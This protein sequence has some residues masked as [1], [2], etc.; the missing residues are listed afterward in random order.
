MNYSQ[1]LCLLRQM[2]LKYI[3]KVFHNCFYGIASISREQITS[4]LWIGKRGIAIS[5]WY[6]SKNLIFLSSSK[7]SLALTVYFECRF[8]ELYILFTLGVSKTQPVFLQWMFSSSSYHFKKMWFW[9]T[10]NYLARILYTN[11]KCVATWGKL[12][13]CD[14]YGLLSFAQDVKI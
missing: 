13:E 8:S 3:T 2:E 14:S 7:T 12:S 10:Y 9:S 5:N 11:V 4:I 6:S 1:Q